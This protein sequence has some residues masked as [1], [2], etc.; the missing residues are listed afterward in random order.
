M[1]HRN[2]SRHPRSR[3]IPLPDRVRNLLRYYIECARED[4]GQSIQASLGD[5]GKRFIPWTFSPDLWPL[6]AAELTVVLCSNQLRF[7]SELRKIGSEG[8]LLYGYP[9]CIEANRTVIPLFTWPIEY[10]LHGRE[11]WLHVAPE[12]PQMNPEYLKKLAETAEEEREILESLG[13][14]DTPDDP[15][16]DL[17]PDILKRMDELG[18]FPDVQETLD[19]EDIVR[20]QPT[21]RYQSAGVYNRA[22]LFATV[23]PSYTRGL[24]RDLEEMVKTGAP[25]W[26]KTALGTMLGVRNVVDEDEQTAVEVVPLNEQQ[27]RAVRMAIS[28][29]LTAVTGPPGTGKSQI[30]VSMIA[31][32]YKHGKRVL[33]TSKNNKAVDVVEARVADLASNPLML[34][35]GSRRGLRN[36]RHELVQRLDS[37][38]AFQASDEDRRKYDALEGKYDELR[39]QEDDLWVELRIVRDANSRLLSLDETQVSFEKEHAPQ[40]WEELQ[41]VKGRPDA[42][43]LSAGLKL[44]DEHIAD[45]N[46]PSSYFLHLRSI[47]DRLTKAI[48]LAETHT[49][50]W[51]I[52]PSHFLHLRSASDRLTK[53]IQ[54][55]DKHIANWDTP[56]SHFLHLRSA[57]DRLTKAIQLADKR[58]ANWDTPPSHFLHLRSATDRL[59]KAIQ[60]AEKHIGGA[61]NLI[62][63]FSLWRSTSK[64]RK[65]IQS[66]ADEAVSVCPAL[67]LCSIDRQSFQAWRNWLI[68]ALYITSKLGAIDRDRERMQSLAAEAMV[69]CPAFDPW[70]TDRRSFRAWRNWLIQALSTA[71]KLSAVDRDRK[72]IQSVAAEAVA[73]C[74]A[75]DPYPIDRQSFQ[76]WRNWLLKALSITRQLSAVDKDRKRIQSIAVDAVTACPAL[77]PLPVD[78]QS[79]KAWFAWLI[80]VDSVMKN[81]EEIDR[82]R[83]RIQSIAAEAVTQFSVLELPAENLSFRAWSAW[84]SRA[85]S[86]VEALDAIAAY[87]NGLHELREMRSRD[88]VARHL[89]RVRDDLADSGAELVTLYARLAPDR[90]APSDREAI[91]SFRALQEQLA[92]ERLGGNEYFQVRRDMAHLFPD[93]SLHIPAWCVT[94]LSA[95]SSLPLEPN[96]FELLIIDEASQCDIASALPLLYR[97]RRAVIIGDTEQLRHV[98]KIERRRDRKLQAD[99]GLVDDDPRAHVFAYSQNSLYDL[100]ISRGAIGE[101]IQLQDHYRSHSDIVGFSNERWYNDSLRYWTDHGR[102]KEPPDGQY[103]IRW[104]EVNGIAQRLRAG[105]VYVLAEVEAIVQQVIELMNQ[106]FDGTV[107]VVTPFRPQANMIRERIS[108]RVPPELLGRAKFIVDTAH[109]FQGDERDI[110]LFSP[111]VAQN[112]PMGARNFLATYDNLFNVAVTRA[113]SQLHV[114]GSRGACNDSGIPHIQRFAAYCTEIERS[115]SSPYETTLASDERV[116]PWERPLYDALVKNGLNPI[117]QHP[118]NQYRLD[119]GN[120][121]RRCTD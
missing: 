120:C 43:K 64:D 70:P 66:A 73:E 69:E 95:R 28:S 16:D 62:A 117:P 55:A 113:R 32:A 94:N 116:G 82:D 33:F 111:C 102:L 112:L 44:A 88:E 119:L 6:G 31:D 45:S 7:A 8:S 40:V 19:S 50:I 71:I 13:L 87:R 104:T 59:T 1:N 93:V 38:L 110:I 23:L 65:R 17:I 60:L 114:V 9:L 75:F 96:L 74:P 25:G 12:W 90:L 42:D 63:R 22:A 92:E 35:T 77:E 21:D 29:P 30:V 89:R 76:A 47:S 86:I 46:I 107:G 101:V 11:L 100:T 99:H 41:K 80:Q 5:A 2:K 61:D 81:L 105:S 10:E 53:A 84:F 26:G 27:R 20:G 37:L 51:D 79:F 54:L 34:R 78:Q 103:G 72:R 106:R 24:I 83:K 109:G 4:E 14:L 115:A 108:Q 98:T 52:P 39:R 85:L 91:G 118:V 49:A 3:D 58:I 121:L 68:Q 97:S 56:S 57:T 36:F 48:Q 67:N 18:L 15:P